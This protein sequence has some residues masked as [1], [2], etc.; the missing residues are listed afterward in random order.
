MGLNYFFD[1]IIFGFLF[2]DLVFIFWILKQKRLSFLKRFSFVFLALLAWGVIFYGSFLEPKRIIIKQEFIELNSNPR[3]KLRVAIISD[4]HV[5][6]YK[7]AGFVKK[8]V[9]Q[10]KEQNPD[11]VLMLGDYIYDSADEV[12][13]LSPLSELTN[14]FT[15]YAVI[16]NHDYDLSSPKIIEDRRLAKVVK[17]KLNDLGV[18]VMEN[19]SRPINS[20]R[21]W[22]AGAKELWT[23]GVTIDQ[24]VSN[25]NKRSNATILLTHNPDLASTITPD[26]DIKLVLAGHTHGGQIRLPL[27]G[28]IGPIPDELGQ[29]YDKGFFE[30]NDTPVYITSG[31]GESGP[32]ARLFNPPEIIMM[33]ID[34]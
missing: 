26:D 19:E 20:G 24:A 1:A 15:T 14:E 31:L 4:I 27:M 13:Y 11:I 28:P 32:R 17:D 23:G 9:D 30:I 22:L 33:E 29:Q 34:Y 12:E 3:D 18:I 25:R 10:I 2:V 7:K 16:G 21:L 8:V 6:P 5:G